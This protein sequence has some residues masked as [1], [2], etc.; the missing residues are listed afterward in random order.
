MHLTPEK[1]KTYRQEVED[2]CINRGHMAI[3]MLDSFDLIEKLRAEVDRLK[4]TQFD[5]LIDT[6][7]ERDELRVHVDRLLDERT[8]MNESWNERCKVA[9]LRARCLEGEVEMVK[10]NCPRVGGHLGPTCCCWKGTCD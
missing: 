1:I 6:A 7:K 4:A 5:V 2:D 8:K 10:K 9:E 3:V